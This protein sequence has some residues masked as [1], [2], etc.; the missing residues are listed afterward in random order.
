M[1]LGGL[2]CPRRVE[3]RHLA[4]TRASRAVCLNFTKENLSLGKKIDKKWVTR[5]WYRHG[6]LSLFSPSSFLI[7]LES[8]L[9]YVI[10][11]WFM[12][13]LIRCRGCHVLPS[14]MCVYNFFGVSPGPPPVRS[15]INHR[16]HKYLRSPLANCLKMA[17]CNFK[18]IWL[19]VVKSWSDWCNVIAVGFSRLCSWNIQRMYR[20]PN[21]YSATP[22]G[23]EE[24]NNPPSKSFQGRFRLSCASTLLRPTV[25]YRLPTESLLG[26][27]FSWRWY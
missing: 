24:F 11:K 3:K 15:H 8:Q 13:D 17:E 9:R 2:F 20:Y 18:K 23:L 26:P 19:N 10:Q 4:V 12:Y 21:R 14:R 6:G 16:A 22:G 25:S 27:L 7:K 1:S 5:V